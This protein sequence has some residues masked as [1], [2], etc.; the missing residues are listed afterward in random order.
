MLFCIFYI[1]RRN[2]ICLKS[3][4]RVGRAVGQSVGREPSQLTSA[5]LEV[6]QSH[7]LTTPPRLA[8]LLPTIFTILCSP[9]TPTNIQLVEEACLEWYVFTRLR[10]FYFEPTSR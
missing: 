9:S 10:H 6:L 1:L 5:A 7:I 2:I 8:D 3:E 4:C